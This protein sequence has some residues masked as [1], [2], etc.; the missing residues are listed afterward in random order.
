MG[1]KLAWLAIAALLVALG[2]RVL[3]DH[4]GTLEEPPA[5]RLSES[6]AAAAHEPAEPLD[7]LVTPPTESADGERRAD[8][9]ATDIESAAEPEAGPE[10]GGAEAHVVGQLLLPSGEPA[11]GAELKLR[12]WVANSVR[13][14]KYG[15]PKNWATVTGGTDDEGRFDMA[16]EPPRAF[17][18]TMDAA[19]E[20]YSELSW[21]WGELLPGSTTDVG[22]QTFKQGC[23]VTGKVVG[24]DGEPTGVHWSVY[25]DAVIGS[26]GEGSDATRVIGSADFATG[27]FELKGVPPGPITLKAHSRKA[28]WIDGPTV[29]ASPGQVVTAEIVYDGPDLRSTISITTFSQPFHIFNTPEGLRIVARGA[30]GTEF[31]AERIEGSSQS[32]RIQDLPPGAYTVEATSPVHEAWTKSGVKPG[33]QISMKLHG[34]ARLALAVVDDATGDPVESYGVRVR[35]NG[36]RWS[37]N[38]F[39]LL[40]R[41]SEPP[42]GGLFERLI[43]WDLTLLVDADGFAPLSLPV[44]KID[45]NTTTSAE[46]R[47][48]R[49]GRIDVIVVDG[50]GKAVAGA[51]VTL[52]P[53]FEGYNPRDVFSGPRDSGQRRAL[54]DATLELTAGADGRAS[55]DAVAPGSYGLLAIAGALDARKGRIEVVDGNR[56]SEALTLPRSGSIEGRLQG[57]SPGSFA[58]V[59]VR[60]RSEGNRTSPPR[61]GRGEVEP[62]T[63]SLG[64]DGTFAIEGLKVGTYQ[65][66]LYRLTR[67]VPTSSSSSS[68]SMS[69]TF[70]LGEVDVLAGPPTQAT[71]DASEHVPAALT[72]TARRNGELAAGILVKI[73][74]GK[75]NGW[76]GAVLSVEGTTRFDPVFPGEWKVTARSLMG[77]WV[78]TCP[79]RLVLTPGQDAT[80]ELSFETAK[81]RVQILD[82]AT[83]EGVAARDVYVDGNHRFKTDEE[84]WLDLELPVGPITLDG[85]RPWPEPSAG[86]VTID[87]GPT[88]PSVEQATLTFG[89]DG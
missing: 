12:G 7:A 46:A 13:E 42:A 40:E 21:R 71:F 26:S 47:L 5:D 56:L 66:E 34:G 52:H 3:L 10:Q 2:A 61:R 80:L 41:G 43:P 27:A 65:L 50:T 1:K 72:V 81:G 22:T 11:R 36:S 31:V 82:A 45:A 75:G 85:V 53:F 74:S 68:G 30:D 33:D 67:N 55:F 54:R 37:P 23:R 60:A 89:D 79:E 62:G 29:E 15:A 57:G 4:S 44:G 16:F 78:Y 14:Q 18:F 28:N 73:R 51:K 70:T 6:A 63:A 32:F 58:R 59:R 20:G 49:G 64:D 83:G 76:D 88:G 87:W 25:A 35:F 24:K 77:G 8:A 9:S 69:N 39:T 86:T 84:G 19:L 38:V 48:S 17:Q